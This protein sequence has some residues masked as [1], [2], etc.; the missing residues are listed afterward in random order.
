MG[1]ANGT[2]LLT[3]EFTDPSTFPDIQWKI[4]GPR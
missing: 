2:T 1:G 3:G 4:V